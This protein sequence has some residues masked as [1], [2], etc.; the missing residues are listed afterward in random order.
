MTLV[1]VLAEMEA[2]ERGEWVG[3]VNVDDDGN[4]GEGRIGNCAVQPAIV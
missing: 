4:G 2:A 1:I 3:G